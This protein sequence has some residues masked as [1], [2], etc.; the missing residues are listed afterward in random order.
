VRS[1]DSSTGT[2]GE[3]KWQLSKEGAAG[4]QTWRADGKEFFFRQPGRGDFAVM[5]AEISTSPTFQHRRPRCCSG[6][7]GRP[8]RKRETLGT[9]AATGSGLCSPWM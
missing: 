6:Y 5:S 2:A 7:P 8:A 1:F 4:M 9:S 3:G